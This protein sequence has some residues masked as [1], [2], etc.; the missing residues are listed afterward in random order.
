MFSG[1]HAVVPVRYWLLRGRSFDCC[2]ATVTREREQGLQ[3]F[4]VVE[5]AAN[6]VSAATQRLVADAVLWGR[7]QGRNFAAN[8]G[9]NVLGCRI[10]DLT[11]AV[12]VAATRYVSIAK[13]VIHFGRF[14]R[15]CCRAISAKKDYIKSDAKILRKN[16]KFQT[17][18]CRNCLAVVKT[19]Y[20][21]PTSLFRTAYV[22]HLNK[23][24]WVTLKIST[25]QPR[26]LVGE[27]SLMIIT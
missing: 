26:N 14:K 24:S 4:V 15:C 5:T 27:K 9:E 13:T 17:F 1:V 22:K 6:V 19:L 10:F 11:K 25:R 7:S 18:K 2:V 23:C 20:V 16:S 21:L 3:V 12:I 8:P